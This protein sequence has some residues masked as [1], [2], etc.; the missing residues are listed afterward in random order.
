LRPETDVDHHGPESLPSG[1][2][3]LFTVHGK[4]NRFSIAAQDLGSGERKTIIESGFSPVYSP[5][6]H[7]LFARG[8]AIMAVPFDE[9]SLMVG[10]EAVTLVERVES[11]PRSGVAHYRVSKNGTLVFQQKYPPSARQLTWVDRT[12]RETPVPV[13]AQAIESARLSPDGKQ[14]VFSAEDKDRRD[15]WLYALNSGGLTRL[16]QDRDNWSPIWTPDGAAVIY[17]REG[18]NVAQVVRHRLDGAPIE[19]LGSTEEDLWP[20]DLTRDGQHLIVT[21]QPPT[22]EWFMAQLNMGSAAPQSLLQRLGFPRLG[23]LSPDGRWLAYGETVGNRTE[24]F[25][26][27]YPA[28]GQRRQ[29][30]TD[31][32]NHPVWRRDGK[33]LFFRR[34]SRMFG[35]SIDTARGLQGGRPALLFDRRYFSGWNSYDVAADGRFLMIK[36]A[37]SE[38]TAGQLNVIVNWRNE[39]L[40]RVPASK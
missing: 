38:D 30:S 5:T 19:T 32:G 28:F 1:R 39:L 34:G 36:P 12:G 13:P 40:S 3:L 33:E 16:T 26:Q 22:D 18:G 29:V 20:T 7:L 9:R 24:V 27:S 31:G 25:I 17:S 4:R 37:P 10:G 15:I 2:A 8:S 14:L 11:D 35:V 21:G 6:G 23:R